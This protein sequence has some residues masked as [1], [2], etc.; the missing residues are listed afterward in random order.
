MYELET[1]RTQVEDEDLDK[2]DSKTVALRKIIIH[3]IQGYTGNFLSLNVF[4]VNSKILLELEKIAEKVVNRLLELN[5]QQ[6]HVKENCDPFEGAS[7]IQM[8][9]NVEDLKLKNQQDTLTK[10]ENISKDVQ[11][12]HEM[13]K[14]LNEMVDVQGENV[15]HIEKTIDSA[16]QNV[17]NGARELMKAHK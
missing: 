1:L 11:D 5:I 8:Q 17:E 7:Q 2:F 16:Q 15:D 13:Y 12:L 9:E 10:V 4:L 3:L 14:D 6:Q